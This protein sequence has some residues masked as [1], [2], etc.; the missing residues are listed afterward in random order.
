MASGGTKIVAQGVESR[1]C[2]QMRTPRTSQ[3]WLS[4]A[5][6]ASTGMVETM[7]VASRS[8]RSDCA[9]SPWTHDSCV[10]MRCLARVIAL[11]LAPSL[12]VGAL[13]PQEAARFALPL[14]VGDHWCYSSRLQGSVEY[15][16]VSVDRR[17][18]E[19]W[20]QLR[21]VDGGAWTEWWCKRADG[22]HRRQ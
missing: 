12:L 15:D 5:L 2:G 8:W 3:R 17:A 21:A 9:C 13:S 10:S 7:V 11:T 18:G 4:G 22:Y 14:R 1:G 20:Y 16:C 19:V 6:D